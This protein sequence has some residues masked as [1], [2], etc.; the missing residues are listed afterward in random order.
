MIKEKNKK[1]TWENLYSNTEIEEII[2]RL[3]YGLK[4]PER[5]FNYYAWLKLI[6]KNN[7]KFRRSIEF[8]CGTGSYSLILKKLGFVDEVYLVDFSEESLKIA[9]RLFDYFGVKGH[10]IHGDIRDLEFKNKFFDLS[11]SGGLI[12]HFEDSQKIKILE[13]KKRISKFILT[14]VP[15]STWTYWIV[16]EIITLKNKFKWPFG[17]EKPMS[18][19]ELLKLYNKLNIEILDKEYHDVLT[20]IKFNKKSNSLAR[21]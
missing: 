2:Q 21:N 7:L 14:Q 16:R 12:E 11:F 20:A 17:Y 1:Q 5:L 18:Q 6:K 13:E 15:I 19:K 4:K 3:E 9:K 8:G 10:F